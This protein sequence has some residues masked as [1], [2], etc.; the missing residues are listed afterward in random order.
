MT[1]LK[2]MSVIL[3][4]LLFLAGCSANE[5]EILKQMCYEYP[6]DA[7][8]DVAGDYVPTAQPEGMELKGQKGCVALYVDV[9]T[10]NFAVEDMRSGQVYASALSGA[11]ADEEATTR[12]KRRMKSAILT[13]DVE[14]SSAVNRTKS[15]Y[16]NAYESGMIQVQDITDGVRIWY[17]FSEEQYA[18]PLD[19]TLCEDGFRCRIACNEI[20][21]QDVCKLFGVSFLPYLYAQKGDSNG[22][23]LVPDGSGGI[24]RF[25]S[26]KESYPTYYAQL[27][28]SNYLTNA[29]YSPTVREENLLPVIGMQGDQGGFLAV[30]ESG[31]EFG[32]V[33]AAVDGQSSSYNNVYFGFSLRESQT[34]TIGAKDSFYSKNIVVKE[35]GPVAVGDISVRYYLLDSTPETG[36]S[37]MAKVAQ[38]ALNK[39]DVV[40]KLRVAEYATYLSVMGG[41]RTIVSVLGIPV[42]K[43]QPLTTV[44]GLQEMLTWFDQQGVQSTAVVYEGFDRNQ[45]K[46]TITEKIVFDKAIG[47]QKA[48][49]SLVDDLGENGLYLAYNTVLY[50]SKGD[51]KAKAIADLSLNKCVLE[52]YKRSTFFP[53]SKKDP[54]YMLKTGYVNQMLLGLSQALSKELP[55]AG[56]LAV[57]AGS[58]LYNDFSETGYRR[59]QAAQALGETMAKL[60]E[61]QALMTENANAYAAQYSSV[62]LNTPDSHS[63]FFLVDEAVPFYQMVFG[64]KRQIVSKAIN[65]KGTPRLAFLNSVRCGMQPQFEITAASAEMLKELNNEGYF[66]AAFERCR[67]DIVSMC[68]EY[69]PLY[70]SI[71]GKRMTDYR[72]LDE[73]V[74]LTVYENGVSVLVNTGTETYQDEQ[75]TVNAQQFAVY[76]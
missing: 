30:A 48:F 28:G 59:N 62:L 38:K 73:G 58:M 17:V 75:Y 67:D 24:I 19:V 65:T 16:E 36:L 26:Q 63:G 13:T 23:M 11:D 53:N 64:G 46:N 70:D 29:D 21:E 7:V 42:E 74:T 14:Q 31:A 37:T 9:E 2:R 71:R 69:Q 32:A 54:W 18:I 68:L 44:E 35:E 6:T 56:L 5:A 12:I 52:N 72:I 15:A 4:T 57:N 39:E 27:Y 45:H 10:G 43:T 34:T 20:Q 55:G 25:S 49:A 41:Y 50:S 51:G 60:S 22:F 40:E 61:N 8:V 47:S 1:W 66:G 33:Y 76:P 3:L